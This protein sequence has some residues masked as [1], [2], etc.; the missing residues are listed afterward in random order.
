M[1]FKHPPGITGIFSTPSV[2]KI[3]AQ[4][5]I[6]DSASI[7]VDLPNLFRDYT[8][9]P[10]RRVIGLMSGTSADGVHAALVE[11]AGAGETTTAKVIA[12]LHE[13]YSPSLRER[14]FRLFD[15]N[16]PVT[17]VC[18]MNFALGEMFAQAALSLANANGGIES[19]DLIAS[20]GQTICHLPNLRSELTPAGATLQIGEPAVIAARTGVTTA[21]DFRVA[22]VAA[23]GQGAPLVPFTDYIL[24]HHAHRGRAIQNIGGIGNVTFLPAG[25]GKD[26]LLAFDT[27]PGNMLIDAV[28]HRLTDGRLD[29][30]LDGELAA[31]GTIDNTLLA[32]LMEHEFIRRDPPKTAGREDFG[33]AFAEEFL[34][35]AQAANLSIEDTLATATAFTARSIADAYQ[36]FLR[37]KGRLDE[38]ILGGGGAYNKTLKEMIAFRLPR[39]TIYKHEDFGIPGHAK[40]AL[41]FAIL[42][43]ELMLGRAAGMPKITGAHRVAMLGKICFG[44]K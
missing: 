20:H 12:F 3:M 2:E 42:G 29:Y 11:I 25:G 28:A 26:D 44:S 43:N 1:L 24:F 17:H 4:D 39:K 37:P 18:E 9:Q 35:R 31:K 5:A 22:D 34:A 36:R 30:D 7:A 21:A 40:E 6:H 16:C 14:I 32:W 27:G 13:P 8:Q 15:P 23:G 33:A 41:A 38:I 19:I 10:V